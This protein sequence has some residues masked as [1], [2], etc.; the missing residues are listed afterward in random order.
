MQKILRAVCYLRRHFY[1][2]D[3]EVYAVAQGTISI[4]GFTAGDKAS[5]ITK[6]VP[7]SG[8]IANGGMVEQEIDF[9][10][11]SLP[12]L[13]M[14]L[15]NPDIS[16]AR[17][18]VEAVNSNIGPGIANV[19]DPWYDHI[20][21]PGSLSGQ[22]QP[23]LLAEVEQLSV[24]TDQIAKIVIDEAS[25]TIVMGENVQI[26]PVAIAQGNLIVKIEKREEVSQ[27]N[28]LA[29]EGAE[30][31][32]TEQTLVTVEELGPGKGIAVLDTGAT[33]KDLVNGLNAARCIATRFDY[34]FTN[35][36]G[37]GC[38][39]S[40]HIN[41]VDMTIDAIGTL[42]ANTG[43][44]LPS[45]PG[46]YA[47]SPVNFSGVKMT[48]EQMEQVA[49][50]FESLFISQMMEQMFD[51]ESLGTDL[52]GDKQTSEIYKGLMLEEYGD[53]ISESGGIGIG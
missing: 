20:D 53:I 36:Q 28:P 10:L 3:G 35:H 49:K 34:H 27:P 22:Y 50:D 2:A 32:T 33:L 44:A 9:D 41:E 5:T 8:Y 39:A 47:S 30:T 24:D 48:P 52:F 38:I 40:R 23:R 15:R 51:D 42:Y 11:N 6:G 21:Y 45:L 18:V 4:G 19:V 31:V 12:E 1:G 43:S 16:T 37:G 7:T 14:A 17:N 29:P 26:D 46:S 13:K 25:G